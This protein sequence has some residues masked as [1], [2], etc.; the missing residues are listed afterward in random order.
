MSGLIFHTNNRKLFR[1]T[2]FVRQTQFPRTHLLSVVQKEQNRGENNSVVLNVEEE[3]DIT[4]QRN[5]HDLTHKTFGTH[6][7]LTMW[8]RQWA[9]RYIIS[10]GKS[11]Y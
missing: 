11:C 10:L 4:F 6:L 9:Y 1:S 3:R 5:S 7:R 2:T 8:F